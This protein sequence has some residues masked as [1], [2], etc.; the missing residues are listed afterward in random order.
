MIKNGLRE[1]AMTKEDHPT[2]DHD[3]PPPSSLRRITP[4]MWR[5]IAAI[6]AIGWIANFDY[7]FSG[8]VLAMP[9]F[10]Q[11]FGSVCTTQL[12]AVSDVTTEACKLSSIQQSLLSVST[13]F[14]WSGNS[15]LRKVPETI[16]DD[17][18]DFL[19]SMTSP[20]DFDPNP[21]PGLNHNDFELLF[22]PS[23]TGIS[24]RQVLFPIEM[25]T[26]PIGAWQISEQANLEQTSTTT[27]AKPAL[28]DWFSTSNSSRA[29]SSP[30]TIPTPPL[31]RDSLLGQVAPS[32]PSNCG[33][34]T[35]AHAVLRELVMD[36]QKSETHTLR[37]LEYVLSQNQTAMETTNS[38]LA[39]PC[40]KDISS[41][42]T[43]ALV[44]FKTLVWYAAAA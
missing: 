16:G 10:N 21:D 24:D 20:P 19:A 29:S 1:T 23:S 36:K 8:I 26:A 43:L 31:R 44:V 17:F 42:F 27:I 25:P 14:Q 32:P 38:V 12:D 2:T 4:F 15:V 7:G 35:K 28:V 37:Q 3:A 40:A 11:A 30:P 18:D 22:T 5:F 33:C 9:S 41:L 13:L 34:S 39:C 6:C